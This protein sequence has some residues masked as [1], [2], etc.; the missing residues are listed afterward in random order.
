MSI[1]HALD[2]AAVALIQAARDYGDL[3]AAS[4]RAELLRRATTL[5]REHGRR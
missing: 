3:A 5:L 2:L 1:G 4:L